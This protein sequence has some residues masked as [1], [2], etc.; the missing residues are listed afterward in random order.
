M[1]WFM[2]YAFTREGEAGGVTHFG[3]CTTAQH[4]VLTVNAWNAMSPGTA[5]VLLFYQQLTFEEQ[6]YEHDV[7]T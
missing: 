2:S 6:L 1:K 4:P 3:S 7:E 5:T